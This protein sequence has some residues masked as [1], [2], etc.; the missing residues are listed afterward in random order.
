MVKY[1]RGYT[2]LCLVDKALAVH[3]A[4]CINR[5]HEDSSS[6]YKCKFTKLSVDYYPIR[7]ALK[8]I[9]RNKCAYCETQFNRTFIKIEH[10]RPKSIYYALAY[11]WS[12]LLPICDIC[13]TKKS[14]NFDVDGIVVKDK[15]RTLQKL[16]YST[17]M[18]NRI[19]KPK[20]LHPEIDDYEDMFRF[21]TKG[22]II[23][24]ENVINSHRMTYS[25]INSDLNEEA[26]M[27]RRAKVL[28]DFVEIRNELFHLFY[29]AKKNKN[30][31][32]LKYFKEN[33]VK[34]I[35]KFFN[36]KNEF[37]AVR[38]YIISRLRFFLSHCDDM[39]VKFFHRYLQK[40]IVTLEVYS[41]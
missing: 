22:K 15:I 27:E 21:N 40:Y 38:K 29:V 39:F 9:Y 2:P 3:N 20:F 32:D 14:N 34:K 6:R 25:I 33:T 17:K 8:E 23:V 35:K 37:I 10:Y 16:Q 7:D 30:N 24:Y 11:S 18:F 12:N 31:E 19:E 26:L 36:D 4:N 1:S 28:Q 13:N 41:N 5:K